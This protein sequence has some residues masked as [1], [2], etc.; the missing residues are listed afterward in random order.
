MRLQ[1]E[2]AVNRYIPALEAVTD[3]TSG[4]SPALL[5]N[6]TVRSQPAVRSGLSTWAS[7]ENARRIWREQHWFHTRHIPS[8]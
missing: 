4:L 3:P 2:P 7:R 1:Q 6:L 8:T 5:A